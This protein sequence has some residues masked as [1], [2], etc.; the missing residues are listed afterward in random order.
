[1]AGAFGYE[2]EHYQVSME[3]A[4]LK[5]LPTIRAAEPDAV[6][7]AT[8]T[9]CRHQI[10]DGTSRVAFHPVDLLWEAVR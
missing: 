10:L 3:I 2:K 5:L 6:I 8:G 4:E 1:M 7:C 9:S